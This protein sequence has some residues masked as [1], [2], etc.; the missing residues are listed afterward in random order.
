MFASKICTL[1]NNIIK[2]HLTLTIKRL[3]Y[4]GAGELVSYVRFVGLTRGLPQQGDV[5][6][7]VG[8]GC[9]GSHSGREGGRHGGRGGSALCT[10][11]ICVQ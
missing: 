2:I 11:S 6:L 7:G 8:G 10:T 5:R 4:L 3:S 1:E 9:R